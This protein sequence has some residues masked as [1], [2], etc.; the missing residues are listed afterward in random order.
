MPR[1]ATSCETMVV[2][3]SPSYNL[4]IFVNL[5][6]VNSCM[7]NFTCSNMSLVWSWSRSKCPSCSMLWLLSLSSFCG[8][9][10][11]SGLGMVHVDLSIRLCPGPE[12]GLFLYHEMT[13]ERLRELVWLLS[14]WCV[15]TK[16]GRLL[17]SVKMQ[18]TPTY[19]LNDTMGPPQKIF[20]GFFPTSPK[21][22]LY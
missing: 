10:S 11:S 21:P 18:L 16:Q 12:C 7:I 14:T 15:C 2:R 4:I 17:Q 22:F 8:F 20:T 6:Q 3:P 5:I 13:Q 9:F 1:A 19:I